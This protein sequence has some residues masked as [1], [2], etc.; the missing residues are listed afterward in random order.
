LFFTGRKHAGENLDALLG[1]RD[2]R[3]DP[4][5]QM[6]DASS[7]D[8]PKNH[9]VQGSNCIAHGRRL[10]VDQVANHPE[11][12]GFLLERLAVVF[13]LDKE[14]KQLGVSDEVRLLAHRNYSGPVMEQLRRWMTAQLDDTRVEPNSGLGKAFKYFLKRW[15]KFTL[16]LRVR[17]APLE[18]NI[19]ERAL[20]M[21]INFRKNSLF[22]RSQRGARVG[23]IFMS[24]IHTAELHHENPFDYLTQLQRHHKAVAASPADWMPW[25]YRSTLERLKPPQPSARSA[26]AS[27]ALAA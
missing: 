20:K 25:N 14:L 26:H 5:I 16:F 13:K 9:H 8:L 4:P 11:L 18:N 2:D 1:L 27:A 19:A 23:D 15:S 12:C 10:V 21:A 3:L 24:L 17:G 6:G 22:Y 7:C